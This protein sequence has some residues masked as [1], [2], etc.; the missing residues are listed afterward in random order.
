MRALLYT[1]LIFST[2]T[3]RFPR[4]TDVDYEYSHDGVPMQESAVMIPSLLDKPL[5]EYQGL[6]DCHVVAIPSCIL[7]DYSI[8]IIITGVARGVVGI[9]K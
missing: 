9:Q 1:S 4:A 2:V 5:G 7:H 3:T 8:I 6:H